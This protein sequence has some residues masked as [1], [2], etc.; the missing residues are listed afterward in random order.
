M[1]VCVGDGAGG[2]P[3]SIW[4]LGGGVGCWGEFAGGFWGEWF[5]CVQDEGAGYF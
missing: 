2:G 1:V 4:L 5:N 3:C